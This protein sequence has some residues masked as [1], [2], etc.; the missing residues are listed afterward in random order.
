LLQKN[1]TKQSKNF[2]KTFL[3]QENKKTRYSVKTELR[4]GD[5]RE[6]NAL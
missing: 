3:L 6:A 5:F 4:S 1:K 2:A